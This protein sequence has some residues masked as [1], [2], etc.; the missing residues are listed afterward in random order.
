MAIYMAIYCRIYGHIWPYMAM[1]GHIWPY[2]AIYMAIYGHI[3]KYVCPYMAIYGHIWP[4]IHGTAIVISNWLKPFLKE[5]KQLDACIT[6]AIIRNSLEIFLSV[7]FGQFLDLGGSYLGL[8]GPL[9]ASPASVLT[10]STC[11]NPISTRPKQ[12]F[13]PKYFREFRKIKKSHF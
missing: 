6:V 11:G 5:Y 3:W 4:Y 10:P 8:L 13:D 9:L 1:Y 2:M 12:I 7:N